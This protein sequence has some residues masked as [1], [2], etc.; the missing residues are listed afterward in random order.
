MA[1]TF[2]IFADEEKG[3][4]LIAAERQYFAFPEFFTHN[5]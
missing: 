2:A 3:E 4:G 5:C 1:F